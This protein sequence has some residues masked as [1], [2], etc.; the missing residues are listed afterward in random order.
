MD[1]KARSALAGSVVRA[2]YLLRV[3]FRP[4]NAERSWRTDAFRDLRRRA[5]GGDRRFNRSPSGSLAAQ[6]ADAGSSSFRARVVRRLW[7]DC[8]VVVAAHRGARP[9]AGISKHRAGLED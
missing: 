6:R 2:G 7:I 3:H 4:E 8:P 5:P 9:L 1:F